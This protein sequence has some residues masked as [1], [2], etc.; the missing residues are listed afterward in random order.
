MEGNDMKPPEGG[1]EHRGGPEREHEKFH[2]MMCLAKSAKMELL[3]DKIKKKIEAAEGKKLDEMAAVIAD[4]LLEKQKMRM[5]FKKKK[6]E[7]KKKL[8]EILME[9]E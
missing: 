2:M 7:M 3:K 4:M 6:H 8:E 5:G 1:W 9:E